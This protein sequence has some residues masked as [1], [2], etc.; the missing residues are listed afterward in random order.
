[1]KAFEGYLTVIRNTLENNPHL[2]DLECLEVSISTI[3]GDLIVMEAFFNWGGEMIV[4]QSVRDSYTME[5]V[6]TK[7]EYR[8]A[9]Q[10]YY[11]ELKREQIRDQKLLKRLRKRLPHKIMEWL[12]GEIREHGCG[13][14]KIVTVAE[15][16]G[17]RMRGKDYFSDDRCP[18][19]TV[20]DDVYGGGYPCE[21]CYSG[22]VYIYIGNGQY[23]KMWVNG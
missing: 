21:D 18:I 8:K 20:Y 1:M 11:E 17:N 5:E 6:M 3:E 13:S 14:Y 7:E 4:G 23:F 2:S 19:R 22:D 16:G 15:C 12:D 9:D 10:E